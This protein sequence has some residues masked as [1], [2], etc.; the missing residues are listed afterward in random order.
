MANKHLIKRSSVVG[1][2]PLAVDLDF[3]ELALNFAD[4]KL[5]FKDASGNV[6]FF[7]T[8]TGGGGGSSV[9]ISTTAP[10]SPSSGDLWWNSEDA[11]LYIYYT[12]TNGS[13]WVSA[14][15]AGGGGGSGTSATVD[16]ATLLSP[17]LLM[18]A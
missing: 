2:A 1:R 13:Q 10:S 5:Y 15:Q 3:G 9:T 17:F 14:T 7:T 8:N 16:Q 12:D 4:G 11:T 6:Q 18:G